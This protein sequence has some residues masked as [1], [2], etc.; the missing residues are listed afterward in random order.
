LRGVTTATVVDTG[1]LY[2]FANRENQCFLT[3]RASKKQRFQIQAMAMLLR[4]TVGSIVQLTV[5]CQQL[6]PCSGR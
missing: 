1:A 2:S 4:L 3:R 5:P 6:P